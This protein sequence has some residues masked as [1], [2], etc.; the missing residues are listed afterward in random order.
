[1]LPDEHFSVDGTLLEAWASM[2]SF[3]PKDGTGPDCGGKN[4]EVDFRG[5]RRKNSMHASTTDGDARLCKNAAGAEAGWRT[6]GTC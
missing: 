5:E 6:W 3:K 1:L 2:K 4:P